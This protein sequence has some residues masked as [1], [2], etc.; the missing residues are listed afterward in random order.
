MKNQSL[1]NIG[2]FSCYHDKYHEKLMTTHCQG[3]NDEIQSD[4]LIDDGSLS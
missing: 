2:Y 3:F 1:T 4:K